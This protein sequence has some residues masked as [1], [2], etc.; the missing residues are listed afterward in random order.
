MNPG[1]K[2]Q[3]VMVVFNV[4]IKKFQRNAEKTGW[5]YIVIPAAIANQLKPAFRKSFRI[6]GKI[7]EVKIEKASL[8]PMG[9]GNFILALN[10]QLRNKIGKG[11]GATLKVQIQEDKRELDISSELLSCLEDEPEAYKAFMKMPPSHRRYY[12]KWITDAKTD[13][14]R[15]KRIAITVNAMLTNKTFGEALKA[16]AKTE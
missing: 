8:L 4:V 14:T 10:K 11:V 3:S 13:Q 1:N 15:V 16:A 12:S 5:T 6:E 9:D 7:D 2:L